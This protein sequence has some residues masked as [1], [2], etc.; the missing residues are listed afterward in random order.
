MTY[1]KFNMTQRTARAY[2]S[3]CLLVGE[4]GRGVNRRSRRL[5]IIKMFE[6]LVTRLFNKDCQSMRLIRKLALPKQKHTKKKKKKKVMFRLLR[7]P[8]GL[9][10]AAVRF[11][12]HTIVDR[13]ELSCRPARPR[14]ARRPAGLGS[15]PQISSDRLLGEK[16]VSRLSRIC[17][18]EKIWNH[19]VENFFL[20]VWKKPFVMNGIGGVRARGGERRK[21]GEISRLPLAL[22]L[23]VNIYYVCLFSPRRWLRSASWNRPWRRGAERGGGWG[24]SG[25]SRDPQGCQCPVLRVSGLSKLPPTAQ[26]SPSDAESHLLR[27]RCGCSL[28]RLFLVPW[29]QWLRLRRPPPTPISGRHAP[30]GRLPALSMLAAVPGQRCPT[31]QE[32][33]AQRQLHEAGSGPRAPARSARLTPAQR[34]TYQCH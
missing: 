26:A 24:G 21:G 4:A 22:G 16:S 10:A 23:D 33:G 1:A 19:K 14:A 2:Y 12:G 6:S 13:S 32:Q 18:G 8:V 17:K 28:R 15:L 5:K 3:N 9:P 34:R 30:G 25:V 11:S 7:E 20:S 27:Q 29:Q 31:C